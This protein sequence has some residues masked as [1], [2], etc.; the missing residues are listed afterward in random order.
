MMFKRPPPSRPT[1]TMEA[2]V[3]SLPFLNSQQPMSLL[4]TL[5]LEFQAGDGSLL[6]RPAAPNVEIHIA[7]YAS[8]LNT[9]I[10]MTSSE[11]I[12]SS[13]ALI[14]RAWLQ[15]DAPREFINSTGTLSNGN[16]VSGLNSATCR[17]SHYR[18]WRFQQ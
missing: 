3:R 18:I 1:S 12:T 10:T 15:V 17:N 5:P 11:T 8:G 4:H 13:E 9:H 16:S 6:L 14:A 7:A 2:S